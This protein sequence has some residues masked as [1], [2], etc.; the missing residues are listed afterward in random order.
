MYWNGERSRVFRSISQSH[1]RQSSMI[2]T[3]I[4]YNTEREKMFAINLH[5][6]QIIDWV[7]DCSIKLEYQSIRGRLVKT[8]SFLLTLSLQIAFK[9]IFIIRFAVC[10]LTHFKTPYTICHH[11]TVSVCQLTLVWE[12][13]SKSFALKLPHARSI[14]VSPC[15]ICAFTHK[16][17]S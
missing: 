11:S 5:V 14:F 3:S 2:E 17:I 4:L 6:N 9:P 13:K 12:E 15:K 10:N 8:V 16:K 7:Q 1:A